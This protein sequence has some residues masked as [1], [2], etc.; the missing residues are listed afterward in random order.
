MAIEVLIEN[1]YANDNSTSRKKTSTGKSYLWAEDSWKG[2]LGGGRSRDGVGGGGVEGV[3]LERP[4]NEMM[5]VRWISTGAVRSF[6]WVFGLIWWDLSLAT[7]IQ[8]QAGLPDWRV[9]VHAQRHWAE[10][11]GAD[12]ACAHQPSVWREWRGMYGR[13]ALSWAWVGCFCCCSSF[14]A[15]EI[16]LIVDMW[17]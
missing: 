16:W 7:G 5:T 14:F 4:Q 9:H 12:L 1:I 17:Q 15:V 11:R 2:F 13:S 10:L 8:R 3:Q 6:C